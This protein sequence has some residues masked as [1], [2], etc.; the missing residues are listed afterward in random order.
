MKRLG[1]TPFL[2]IALLSAPACQT[3]PPSSQI[4]VAAPDFHSAEQAGRS[5]F[6]AL[7]CDDGRAE[8]LA[9]GEPLKE[10]YGATLD[11]YLL[12]R[13]DLRKELGPAVGQAWRL[14]PIGTTQGEPGQWVHWGLGKRV[15]V[16]LLMQEQHYFEF[17][18]DDG[19]LV[20]APLNGPA[21]TLLRKE[22]RSMLLEINDPI[23]RSLGDG[24]RVV[25]LTVAS[26]WKIADYRVP[27]EDEN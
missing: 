14:E 5:F 17:R 19:R 2:W 1:C 6:A 15:V 12:G 13:Q 20:G 3:C 24:S 4:L 25:G 27:V 22:G 21:S 7:G 8:Y 26:E 11:L 9:F 10:R 23:L 16:S 18:E